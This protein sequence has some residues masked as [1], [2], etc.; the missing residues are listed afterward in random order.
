[1]IA[2]WLDLRSL[3]TC[4]QLPFG[5]R[6][7]LHVGLN[8]RDRD[9]TR[10]FW[11][12]NPEDPKSAFQIYRFKT[13]LFG[14]TSSP[15]M[16]NATIHH[17]LGNDNTSITEKMKENIYVDNIIS[18]CDQEQ[19]AVAYYQEARSIM[20]D[21]HFNLR[22]RSSNSPS[23]PQRMA[24]PIHVKTSTFLAGSGNLT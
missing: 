9:L 5:S 14:S 2:S 15:F 19:E 4:A 24:L 11:L 13:V 1:M 22:S 6:T 3:M 18:G 12:S 20:D 17:Q 16:L 7:F 21:A 8:Q 10:F 23:K